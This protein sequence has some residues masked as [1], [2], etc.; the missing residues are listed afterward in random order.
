MKQA[1]FSQYIDI[2]IIPRYTH[3]NNRSS[4]ITA[5]TYTQDSADRLSIT[6]YLWKYLQFIGYGAFMS[7]ED[8]KMFKM[9]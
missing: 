3:A 7:F 8:G 2:Q 6:H 1:F 9:K 5:H 4:N